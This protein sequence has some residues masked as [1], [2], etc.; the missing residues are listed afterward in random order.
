[1]REWRLSRWHAQARL[2]F[3]GKTSTILCRTQLARRQGGTDRRLGPD[4]RRTRNAQAD[5]GPPICGFRPWAR[6]SSP[7]VKEEGSFEGLSSRG[8]DGWHAY[9]S[10][11]STGNRAADAVILGVQNGS[12][13]WIA[14]CRSHPDQ[15]VAIS[16]SKHADGLGIPGCLR[17]PKA[18]GMEDRPPDELF[19]EMRS[20]VMTGLGHGLP[21]T[22]ALPPT[23]RPK[24]QR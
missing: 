3:L 7:T 10:A 14:D 20:G 12:G 24:F 18:R 8:S 6:K 23:G 2:H 19:G 21:A 11:L 16:G 5:R 17:P 4:P 13:E 9:G 22:H 1:M 15:P